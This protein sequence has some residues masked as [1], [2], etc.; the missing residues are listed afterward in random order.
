MG[1]ADYQFVEKG[2]VEAPPTGM[3]KPE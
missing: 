1:Y 3:S 2:R